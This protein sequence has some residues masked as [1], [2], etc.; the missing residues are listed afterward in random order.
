MSEQVEIIRHSRPRAEADLPPMTQSLQRRFEAKFVVAESGC[1]LWTAA[2]NGVGYGKIGITRK[3]VRDAHRV[4]WELYR[5]DIPSGM[6]VLHRCDVKLCVN[7]EHLYLGNKTRN[8]LDAVERGQNAVG[9]QCSFAKLTNTD[10]KFIRRAYTAGVRVRDLMSKFNVSESV[11]YRC[12]RRE[13]YR[14]V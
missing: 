7:P 3:S 6:L 2:Q 13:S 4:S 1:W 8:A 11:I 12:V 10:V 5:G 14:N 9:A